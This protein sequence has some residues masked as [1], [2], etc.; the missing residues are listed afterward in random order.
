MA[1]FLAEAFQEI[2][3]ILLEIFTTSML[4]GQKFM[5]EQIESVGF[6]GTHYKHTYHIVS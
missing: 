1:F 5:D 3:F 2:V 4:I 6:Y